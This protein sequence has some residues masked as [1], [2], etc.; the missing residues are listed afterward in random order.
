MSASAYPLQVGVARGIPNSRWDAGTRNQMGITPL[1][2][3]VSGVSAE[4]E[5]APSSLRWALSGESKA[6]TGLPW[7]SAAL[8][9]PS[10]LLPGSA[11][12]MKMW[13]A[14]AA[15]VGIAPGSYSDGWA[16]DGV[17]EKG[18][19]EQ[20]ALG[21]CGFPTFRDS[22]GAGVPAPDKRQWTPCPATECPEILSPSRTENRR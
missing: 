4:T 16:P 1:C 15:T 8:H 9:S 22:Q 17:G 19:D 14:N 11:W 20:A 10:V 2:L 7:A 12:A 6:S 18:Q 13:S 5:M 3:S 21:E